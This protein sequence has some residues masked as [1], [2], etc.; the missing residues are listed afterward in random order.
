MKQFA[1]IATLAL[2]ALQGSGAQAATRLTATEAIA[3]VK[4]TPQLA[5]GSNAYP[6]EAYNAKTHPFVEV[7]GLPEGDSNGGYLDA[8]FAIQGTLSN[9]ET[10][11]AIPLE[12]GGSGGVFTQLVFARI[13]NG[14]PF[15]YAGHIDSTGHLGIIV[16]HGQIV[17]RMPD[18]GPH[19]ANC[20][21]S[22]FLIQKYDI[23]NGKL[24][25]TLEK[26][27]PAPASSTP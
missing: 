11:L 8:D 2:L 17:A 16:S 26:T 23:E 15:V 13:K 6:S 7:L 3:L 27:V 25:K 18:Y 14:A 20:C 24:H 21:P 1:A 12:S 22:K 5:I 19:D 9:G 4:A 10:A